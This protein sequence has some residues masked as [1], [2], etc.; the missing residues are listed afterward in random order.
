V[1]ASRRP[2]RSRAIAWAVLIAFNAAGAS[3]VRETVGSD[4]TG[5]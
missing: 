2:H 3:I 1:L 5:P 4:A